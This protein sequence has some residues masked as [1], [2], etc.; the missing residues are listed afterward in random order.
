M[1][2]AFED[3]ELDVAARTLVRDGQDVHIEPQVFDLLV[4]LAQNANRVVSYDEIVDAVWSGRIVSDSAIASRINAARTAVGDNGKD[5]RI[6]RTVRSQGFRFCV[7]PTTSNHDD[8]A[9]SPGDVFGT[10]SIAAL[11]FSVVPEDQEIGSFADGIVEDLIGNLSR[12][13]ELAVIARNTSFSFRGS[14]MT[15]VDIGKSLQ[16]KYILAGSVRHSGRRVR[17]S[18]ELIETAQAKQIWSERYDRELEDVFDV[19][20][21]VTAQAVAAIA[22]QTQ[23]AEMSA[24]YRKKVESLNAWEQVMR[25]RWHMDKQTR[26]DIEQALDILDKAKAAASNLAIVH[27]T[28]ALC[29]LHRMLNAWG[30]GPLQEIDKA[31][32]AAQQAVA[33]DRDDSSARAILGLAAM[34]AGRLE[35]CLDLLKEAQSQ[36]A[37]LASAYGF[38][39]TAYGCLGERDQALANHDKAIALSP[40]DPQRP[41]WM[42]GKGIALFL[43]RQYDAC[44]DNA[45]RMLRIQEGYGPALRQK[46]ASHA[47]L[48]QEAEAQQT[49][50]L[51]LSGMPGLTV[52]RVIEMVPIAHKADQDHWQGALRKAGLP[53]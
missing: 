50:Q 42:S 20:D 47:M 17:I 27:S 24:A 48:G 29:F 22:P 8:N 19:Q 15:A 23:F 3:C 33:L 13:H 25:A 44:L 10:P 26:A 7:T 11:P 34:F 36:N 21:D 40:R 18:V 37:N 45:D 35:E 14:A 49:M 41:F 28:E 52:Q 53:E 12:F 51:I 2:F 31:K 1:R 5:Q 32:K 43:D 38:M 16:V 46:A 4:L 6:I 39:A 30:D 9:M